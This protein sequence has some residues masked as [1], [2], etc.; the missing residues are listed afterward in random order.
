MLHR[1]RHRST[2]RVKRSV[3]AAVAVAAVGGG[4]TGVLAPSAN[5]TL[6][7]SHVVVTG[8]AGC[9]AFLVFATSVTFNLENGETATSAFNLFSYRVE[10]N[11]IGPSGV[12]GTATVTCGSGPTAYTYQRAVSINRQVPSRN[13]SLNL[14]AG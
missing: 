4:L 8:G 5:A 11:N 2:S 9:R 10:F 7:D 13:Q 6:G 12:N 14:A 1:A 3:A